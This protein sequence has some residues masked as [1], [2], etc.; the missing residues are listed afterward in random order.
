MP[1]LSQQ[2]LIIW[3]LTDGKP[4]H[5]KQSLGLT[6]ALAR[7]CP[8][9]I[10]TI[11]LQ[12][13]RR[14]LLDWLLRRFPPGA[15]LPAPD[16]IVGAGHSTH[17]AMLAAKRAYG[18]RSVVLMKPSLP[19][20]LFDLCIIPEHDRPPSRDNVIPIIGAL[21][22]VTPT[23]EKTPGH[24]L[25]LLGGTSRHY[26]W[27]DETVIN[28]ILEIVH[29]SPETAWRLAT[30]RRTPD[31]FLQKLPTPL[32]T[33]LHIE[34]HTQTGPDWLEHSLA[35]ATT[36]W[37]TEDSVSMLYEAITSGAAIGLLRLPRLGD[38]RVQQGVEHLVSRGWVTPFE[39]W[40]AGQDLSPPV[41][42][43]DEATRTAQ[44]VLEKFHH[45]TR[46]QD[47]GAR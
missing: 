27:D 46:G 17:L 7:I 1:R 3:R 31:A 43:L 37:V 20:G 24:G 9:D 39:Q 42:A 2:P 41:R 8:C 33:N 13:D 32:P 18:G 34:P 28:N 11:R 45:R 38:S 10:H 30:S 44:L 21:N 26:T 36:V 25:I 16:I 15:H 23:S 47:S 22:T 19:L 12:A 40:Q 35:A 6:H 5:E 29:A 14:F 4:G